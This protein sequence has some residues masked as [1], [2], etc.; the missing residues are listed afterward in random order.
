VLRRDLPVLRDA[1][2]TDDPVR[3]DRLA[4]A[5]A[6]PGGDRSGGR[7]KAAGRGC[8]SG[9][10]HDFRWA[11]ARGCPSARDAVVAQNAG[12]D[13]PPPADR[14]PAGP[15]LPGAEERV[16]LRPG[17]FARPDAAAGREPVQAEARA[18]SVFAVQPP[19][20]LQACQGREQPA[21]ETERAEQLRERA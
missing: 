15:E 13:A 21:A 19:E 18:E 7:L 16:S 6:G 9:V 3:R 1:E 20:A 12:P 4:D 10:V 2:R 8:P 11:G 5:W 17:P 14:S